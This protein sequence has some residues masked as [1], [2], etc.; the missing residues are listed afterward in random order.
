MQ[1]GASHY[2]QNQSLGMPLQETR[3]SAGA[4]EAAAGPDAP[5]EWHEDA[6]FWSD[7]LYD[8]HALAE[9]VQVED[10]GFAELSQLRQALF[11]RGW[12]SPSQA[13]ALT[14]VSQKLSDRLRYDAGEVIHSALEEK[15][16]GQLRRLL[17]PVLTMVEN[18]RAVQLMQAPR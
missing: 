12:I 2:A 6:V 1:V 13:T 5:G 7:R 16:E 17:Q 18:V 4:S 3:H 8:L 14:E 9:Q 15:G 11:E 10:V